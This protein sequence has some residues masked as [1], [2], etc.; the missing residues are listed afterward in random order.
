MKEFEDC[1][2]FLEEKRETLDQER[3]DAEERNEDYEKQK[4]AK[5]EADYKRLIA[6]ITRDK[7]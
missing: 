3:K 2:E 1:I 6:K 4:K 5:D 7:N